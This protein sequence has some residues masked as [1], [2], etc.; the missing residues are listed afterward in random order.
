MPWIILGISFWYLKIKLLDLKTLFSCKA[1]F[2]TQKLQLTALLFAFCCNKPT[3]RQW[4]S[5]LGQTKIGQGI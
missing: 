5:G 2:E 3:P 4:Q 1:Y